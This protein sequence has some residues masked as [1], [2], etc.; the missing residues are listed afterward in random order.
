MKLETKKL[1]QKTGFTL[2]EVLVVVAIFAVCAVVLTSLF[3][4]QNRI[5]KTETAE[6]NVTSDARAALDDIDNFVRAATRTMDTYSTYTA[7]SQVL[8]L[9]I[10]SINASNQL[11][12]GVYDYAVYYLT[13]NDLFREIFPDPSSARPAQLKKLA[14]NVTGLVFTYNNLDLALVTQVTT[15]LTIQENAGV[16]IRSITLSSKARLRNH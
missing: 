14:S 3:I 13:G 10:Q 11:L 2:I 8:I 4:G 7:G 9:Q 16:Q 12:P 15:D 6:L 1:L 5:Y